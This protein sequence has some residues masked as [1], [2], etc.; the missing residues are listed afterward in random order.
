[1]AEKI[2]GLGET[3]GRLMIDDQPEPKPEVK[4]NRSRNR[5]RA[6]RATRSTAEHAHRHRRRRVLGVVLG[7]L[8]VALI[9]GC[10][11]DEDYLP[12]EAPIKLIPPRRSTTPSG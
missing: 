5:A 10:G 2:R 6:D 1:M 8:T 3:G 11:A 9:R 12:P 7:S 4:S